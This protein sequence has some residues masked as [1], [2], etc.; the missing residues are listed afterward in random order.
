[1]SLSVTEIVEDR[2]SVKFTLHMTDGDCTVVNRFR[3]IIMSEIPIFA[4]DMVDITV[5]TS[6][7]YDEVLSY[8]LGLIPVTMTSTQTDYLDLEI[9]AQADTLVL[10]RDL[11][12]DIRPVY[13]D[14]I[15]CKLLKGQSLKLRAHVKLGTGDEDA[16]WSPVSNIACRPLQKHLYEVQ[17][18]TTGSIPASSLIS[19]ALKRFSA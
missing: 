5:N 14:I 10:S 3:Q 11:K 18:R 16:K 15:I 12:G 6:D 8:R 2:T 19:A 7:A 9:T 1:M 17:M 4:I 13:D